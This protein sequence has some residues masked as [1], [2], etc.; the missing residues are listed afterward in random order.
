MALEGYTDPQASENFDLD[1][2]S[3]AM[4]ENSVGRR[5]SAWPTQSQLR[6]AVLKLNR[7]LEEV[8]SSPGFYHRGIAIRMLSEYLLDLSALHARQLAND[9]EDKRIANAM[10][11][12]ENYR[13]TLTK[14]EEAEDQ[15]GRLNWQELTLFKFMLEDYTR[16]LENF[17]QQGDR[18]NLESEL[19]DVQAHVDKMDERFPLEFSET[20]LDFMTETLSASLAGVEREF[21]ECSRLHSSGSIQVFAFQCEFVVETL[22]Q[23]LPDRLRRYNE[24]LGLLEDVVVGA[25]E[26]E[27]R[28]RMFK[29]VAFCIESLSELARQLQSVVELLTLCCQE[30]WWIPALELC[31]VTLPELYNPRW[32]RF[33]LAV[34]ACEWSIDVVELA[35][36]AL[37]HVLSG[38]A[39]SLDVAFKW[40]DTKSTMV[41]LLDG[42]GLYEPE[43][44]VVRQRQRARQRTTF[45]V[46]LFKRELIARDTTNL[47][48]KDASAL[49]TKL[50]ELKA[51][52]KKPFS[53][54]DATVHAIADFISQKLE[55][56][57]PKVN[58]L[59]WSHRI[60]PS[61]LT[62]LQFL[63]SGASG[64]VAKFSWLGQAVGVKTLKSPGL[65][66]RR[67]EEEASVL[68]TAQHPRV[69]RMIGCAFQAE[70]G[71]LVMELME[72][73]LRTV[74]E[75]QCPH[76]A[77]GLSPFPVVVAID[78]MLQIGEGMHYV[79]EHC[80]LLH[81]G[82]RAKHIL[83]NRARRV[84]RTVSGAYRKFPEFEPLLHPEEHYIAKLSDFGIGRQA[85]C[86]QQA[87]S[88]RAP[89]LH[90]A[91]DLE[92]SGESQRPADVYS[93][94]MTCY[95]ILTGRVPFD[96]VPNT[97]IY[98]RAV[99]GIRPSL[100]EYSMPPILK[101]LIERCWA[102]DPKERPNFAE[103]C[104][105]LWQCK[106]ESIMSV[107]RLEIGQWR[108][109]SSGLTTCDQAL[110]EDLQAV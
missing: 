13:T 36:Q 107:F 95:E 63:A 62:F 93:F 60:N 100:E 38:V 8:Q 106:V 45:M 59:P 47:E 12:M 77:P 21:A 103:I 110:E 70:T 10:K 52:P 82:L 98:E 27:A 92:M 64:R 48:S 89:E 109:G 49:I 25:Y 7:D 108:S 6:I 11:R 104:R 41:L 17:L 66:Q 39:A 33:S 24:T 75:M 56:P 88:W 30:D 91:L 74:I 67:F 96:D 55:G 97:E 1:A 32:S 34:R 101:G 31:C 76:P 23:N 57:I 42:K 79:H 86:A 20:R 105:S 99:G 53:S 9:P 18:D 68:A 46:R 85:R 35:F 84:R 5:R 22:S 19:E 29:S 87:T 90:N 61:S 58:F 71:S 94:A 73:N 16:G 50:T 83:V 69:V 14:M 28:Q 102:T 80:E 65:S 43:E 15:N 37:K 26:A 72:H 2:L 44:E 54:T 3:L 51:N 4:G 40:S 78:I 81:H